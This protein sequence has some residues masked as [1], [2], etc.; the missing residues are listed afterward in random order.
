MLSI[1]AS[2]TIIIALAANIIFTGAAWADA[3]N[4]VANSSYEIT[5]NP[6]TD[7]EPGIPDGI[8]TR[9]VAPD[10]KISSGAG[11]CR[12]GLFG[13]DPKTAWHG[14]QS[15]MLY[16]PASA[17]NIEQRLEIT[18]ARE[19]AVGEPYTLS[20]YMKSDS[21]GLP[22]ACQKWD[23]KEMK[24]S[25]AW[26]RYSFTF[27]PQGAYAQSALF[28][29]IYGKGAG[30]KGA[31]VWIDAVQIERGTNAAPYQVSP[32]D[33][34]VAR[35][36]G[37]QAEIEKLLQTGLSELKPAKLAAAPVMDGKLTDPCWAQA[38]KI[39]D[40]L[41]V[42][43]SKL[44]EERTSAWVFYNDNALYIALQCYEADIKNIVK[45]QKERDGD[46]F[47]DDCIEVFLDANYDR[48]TY[49]HFAL[50]GLGTQY[51][52]NGS[53]KSW[54]HEWQ[55]AAGADSNCWTAELCLPLMPLLVP[56]EDRTVGLNLCREYPRQKE[57][58]AWSPTFTG[59]HNP[60]RFG[61]LRNINFSPE[62]AGWRIKALAYKYNKEQKVLQAAA[63][64]ENTGKAESKALLKVALTGPAKAALTSEK[65]VNLKPQT[66]G[67]F[68]FDFALA[69]PGRYLLRFH[70]LDPGQKELYASPAIEINILSAGPAAARQLPAAELKGKTVIGPNKELLV[71]GRPVFPLFIYDLIARQD[72]KAAREIGLNC[73]ILPQS[74]FWP[75]GQDKLFDVEAI[76]AYL[77]E[78]QANQLGVFI[79]V[80]QSYFKDY[81]VFRQTPEEKKMQ[82]E[83]IGKIIARFKGHPALWGWY[84]AD[85]PDLGIGAERVAEVYAF[86]RQADPDHFV[87]LVNYSPGSCLDFF[88]LNDVVCV[89]PYPLPGHGLTQVAEWSDSARETTQDVKPL[90]IVLQAFANAGKREPTPAEETCM[91]YLALIH[92]ARGLGYFSFKPL[93]IPL[94]QA[95]G[96]LN[97]EIAELS[98]V[99]FAP[100]AGRS[101]SVSPERT[102]V[103]CRRKE[104]AGKTYLIAVNSVNSAAEVEFALPGLKENTPIKVLF[105]DRIVK[106]KAGGFADRFAGYTR[107]V[108]EISE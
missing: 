30:A 33:A 81:W 90:W 78:A 64:I 19:Y 67:D 58:S 15:L 17:T 88:E 16:L 97:R 25:S 8:A 66:A 45:E 27:T 32:Y 42:D 70:L 74:V 20:F 59:F 106:S 76:Q 61:S 100:D 22:V 65:P 105:E 60:R 21:P 34:E 26:E 50:N 43:G 57:Y 83:I 107:H 35:G 14:K 79:D 41:L 82:F 18:S 4:L 96:R 46:V 104:H 87:W 85:E 98:P 71:H 89:D 40:L 29:S 51:D 6:A 36:G 13:T 93:Y 86:V 72:L 37:Q 24:L 56:G 54:N 31:T 84:V 75:H 62:V 102:P 108:Y 39:S 44:P 101:V 28:I 92:G 10:N 69:Q 73:V 95:I 53:D 7:Q 5:T 103:H 48:R 2:R 91:A 23:V 3:T 68:A 94:W 49:Y 38:S 11:I 55:G 63:S 1:T 77:D 99:L 80:A 9:W 52:A 47:R 12:G